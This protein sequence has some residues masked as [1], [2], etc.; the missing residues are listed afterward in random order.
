MEIILDCERMKYPYTGLFEYCHQ[1]GLALFQT[2]EEKDKVDIYIQKRNQHFFP[3]ET[4]FFTQRSLHKLFYPRLDSKYD[5]WHATHQTSSYIPSRSRKIKCVLTIHDLNFLYEEKS[6]SK[7]AAY[8]KMHQ[9][10]VDKADHIVAISEFTKQ[11]ILKHLVINKPITVIYNGCKVETYPDFNSPFYKPEKPFLFA[12]GTVNAKKNFHVLLCLL[13]NQD[14]E[15]II[16]G[17]TDPNYLQ[18]VMEEARKYNVEDQVKI[19]GG[20]N[21]EDK[22][23]YYKNCKA[24][25]FPSKAEGFGIPVIEAMNF[26]KPVF[27]STATC[28]PEIG[29]KF[30]YYFEDFNPDHMRKVFQDGINDYE[31]RQP[32]QS[33]INHAKQ[34][35]WEVSAKAYW[36]VYKSLAGD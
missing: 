30:A 11:D 17:N 27:L 14:F 23:W 20:I 9:D 21:E 24:F 2:K 25:L 19:L 28:L 29:G 18:C 16:G 36:Q 31:C 22:Y 4:N 32:A 26:G 10:N 5:I 15:L 1:L 34:F 12:L 8:L 33:I 3:E 35:N 7:R 6:S 13:Q